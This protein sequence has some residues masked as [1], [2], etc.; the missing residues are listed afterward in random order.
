MTVL[1]RVFTDRAKHAIH[2]S[3][4]V[5]FMKLAKFSAGPTQIEFGSVQNVL[6]QTF[7]SGPRITHDD[8]ATHFSSVLLRV[9]RP[10]LRIGN[11]QH[12]ITTKRRIV[13]SRR[14]PSSVWSV[15]YPHTQS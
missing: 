11:G 12:Q 14:R 10:I 15:S 9:F 6:I 8:D 5:L 1:H 7:E 2:R 4:H 13:F 3:I